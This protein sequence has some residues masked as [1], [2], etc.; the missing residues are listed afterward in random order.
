MRHFGKGQRMIVAPPQFHLSTRA[1]LSMAL[2]F[3]FA[4]FTL[5][6]QA[7]ANKKPTVVS[8]NLCTDQLVLLLADPE[9]IVSLSYLS[10]DARTSVYAEKAVAYPTNRGLAEE[11]YILK[12]DVT[13]TGTYSNWTAS[14]MLEQLGM[15]VERFEP[16]Y[17]FSDITANIKAMGELLHQ[18]EKAKQVIADFE[19]RLASF[20][21]DHA[22]Q[23]RAAL[24]AA[25]GYTSGKSSIAHHILIAA[26]FQNIGAELGYDYGAKLAV[27]SLLMTSPD[28]IVTNPPGFGHAKA[29]EM[30]RHPALDYFQTDMPAEVTT[31]KNW[32]CDTPLVLDAVAEL[33]TVR[34]AIARPHSKTESR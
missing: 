4:T 16:A 7:F 1:I 23:P 21:A 25:N 10:H 28:L 14:S 29:E 15:R 24:Y 26:G 34:E 13:V 6:H 2:V 8:M 32:V 3:L 27:E 9:Q 5:P 20:Q 22:F 11:V 18:S 19:A 31:N 12:P 17:Q 33:A 30:T